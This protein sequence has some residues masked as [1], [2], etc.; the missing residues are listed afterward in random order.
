[1]LFAQGKGLIGTK[2]DV[3]PKTISGLQLWLDATRITGVADNQALAVWPDMSGNGNHCTQNQA[4]YKPIYSAHGINGMPEVALTYKDL[5]TVSTRWMSVPN[6]VSFTENNCT[7]IC[8]TRPINKQLCGGYGVPLCVSNTKLGW[9]PTTMTA[10]VGGS[11]LYGTRL[12]NHQP[13]M[14]AII[15]SPSSL[16]LWHN[17][18]S[19]SFSPVAATIRTGGRIGTDIGGSY[20]SYGALSEAL[21]YNRALSVAEMNLLYA[22]AQQKYFYPNPT[23]QI[24]FDGD[25]LTTGYACINH[26]N[27][28]GQLWGIMGR[29]WKIYNVCVA[30]QTL[31][32]MQSDAAT[33]IDPLYSASLEKNVLVC[34]EGLLD[35]Y[36]GATPETALTRMQ[37]YCAAR[38]AAGWKVVVLTCLP[39]LYISNVNRATLNA[40]IRAN[41]TNWADSLADIAAD[42]RI[43]QDNSNDDATYFNNSDG[44]K[45]HLTPA[46]FAIVASI[47]ADAIRSLS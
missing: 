10:V 24:I 27:F 18:N 20:P 33:E 11:L 41:W 37:T 14:I 26:S 42:S 28:P 5:S 25:S 44:N 15:S 19:D 32:N 7:L 46:G 38:R 16:K 34:W 6:G 2:G 36:Y 22:Y 39:S 17:G 9:G 1:M 45:T 23:K 35:V 30:G 31:Q 12:L 29:D 13:G 4:V 43:G 21:V 8:I 3:V 40:G 47:T